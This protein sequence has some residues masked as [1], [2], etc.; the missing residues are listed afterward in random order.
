MSDP[1]QGYP[2]GWFVIGWA[3]DFANGE[4]VSMHYFGQQLVGY[5]GDDGKVVVLDAYCPHLGAD[6]GVGG[7]VEGTSIRC[8]FH[9]WR[10]GSDGQCNEIPYAEK[11][12]KRACVN[13]WQVD[14]RNGL[15]F[16]WYGRD[17]AEPSYRIP[18]MPECSD[19]G[20]TRWSRHIKTI[21]TKPKE[22]IENV[23]DKAHFAP[24]HGT[25]VDNFDNEF[26]D[27]I[28]IQRTDGVAYP[29]GGGEDKFKLT[30]T[31]FGPAYQ[32]TEMDSL[33]PNKLLNCHVPIDENSLHLRFGVML[34]KMAPDAKMDVFTQ[35]YIENLEVGFG[36]DVRIWENK[37]WRDRPM[38]RD[39]DGPLGKLRKWYRQF[40]R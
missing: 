8:P 10:F 20:W 5:R 39:G 32:I 11:I 1:L 34:K 33:M 17:G 38:Y 31:Y 2:R 6:L 30:A 29:R 26:V 16:L 12:P 4:V 22:I 36:E 18:E 28:A 15:V 37:L 40:Y 24:V 9:A 21:A 35:K 23:A 25:H 19:P 3:D 7:K 27:H 13:A 14:E